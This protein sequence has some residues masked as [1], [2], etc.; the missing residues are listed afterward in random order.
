M[1]SFN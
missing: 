1:L